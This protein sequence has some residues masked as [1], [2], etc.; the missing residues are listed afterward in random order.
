[1]RRLRYW[2]A[3]VAMVWL[4]APASHA[5]GGQFALNDTD[6]VLFF[7]STAMWPASF[8]MQV[9]TFV[10]VKYPALKTRFWHWGPS[11]PVS[12]AEMKPRIGDYLT[13]FKPTVVVLNCGLDDGEMKPLVESKLSAFRADLTAVIDQCQKAGAKVI[14]VTPNCPEKTR[15]T[16]LLKADYDQVVERYAQVMRDAGSERK[17][18][19]VDWYAATRDRLSASG[20]TRDKKDALTANG[21]HPTPLAHAIATDLLL[22]ALGAEPH[23]VAV[24]VD[25]ASLEASTTA[26]SI[27]A[28]RSNDSTITLELARFPMPWVLPA[29]TPAPRPDWPAAR[30]CRFIFQVHN[31]PPGGVLISEPGRRATPWLE[32]MLEEGFDMASI[33][34]LVDAKPVQGLRTLIVKRKNQRLDSYER[35][36]KKPFADPEYAEANAKYRQ[37]LVAEIEAAA[38]VIDRTPRTMDITLEIKLARPPAEE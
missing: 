4:L 35:F 10:R 36:L 38:R 8:G 11:L 32:Q 34:P 29:G 6:R 19:V 16:A 28:T 31:A 26:G 30:F 27:K 12:L 17:L 7:G 22:E 9:E 23:E 1:M 18:T 21:L 20:E 3:V 37:A 13:P 14:L 33:G 15:K 5:A 2:L 25:W 24:H